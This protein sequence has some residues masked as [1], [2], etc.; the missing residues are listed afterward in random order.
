MK[1]ES[2]LAVALMAI[3]IIG[4]L[5]SCTSTGQYMPLSNDETAIGTVQAIFV[6]KS[7]MFFM[8]SAKNAVSTQAYIYLME[9][10][11]KKYSGE[12]DVRDIVWVTGRS[13]DH[14]H[15]EISASGKVI[16]SR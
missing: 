15:T 16:Q 2:S 9:A 10:A 6:T 12:I 11:E 8:Q 1:T 7:S 5:A 3:L 13:V 4:L 14:Q